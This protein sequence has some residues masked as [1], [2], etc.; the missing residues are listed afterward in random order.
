MRAWGQAAIFE[1][2]VFCF[3][4]I[5]SSIN[6]IWL[7]FCSTLSL[8]LNMSKNRYDKKKGKEDAKGTTQDLDLQRKFRF[9]IVPYSQSIPHLFLFSYLDIIV[10]GWTSLFRSSS[11]SHSSPAVS[12]W[13]VQSVLGSTNIIQA[14][15]ISKFKIP[16]NITLFASPCGRRE[17]YIFV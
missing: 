1:T 11:S 4:L 15:P 14:K 13:L 16:F 17:V 8:S 3:W 5:E 10:L 7:S 2:S 9:P 6:T 12:V